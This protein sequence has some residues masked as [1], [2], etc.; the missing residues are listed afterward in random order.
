MT[1]IRRDPIRRTMTAPQTSHGHPRPSPK[2]ARRPLHHPL[3]QL[4]TRP[5]PRH[6]IAD[7]VAPVWGATTPTPES[8]YPDP[9][10]AEAD[11]VPDAAPATPSYGSTPDIDIPAY[12]PP[13]LEPAGTPEATLEP[14]P[15]PVMSPTGH[16]SYGSVQSTGIG[17]NPFPPTRRRRSHRLRRL[18]A[19]SQARRVVAR[20][21]P[22]I[23]AHP[24]PRSR[25]RA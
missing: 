13:P 17:S 3:L 22:P 6:P 20:R 21:T 24:H 14:P 16:G 5:R 2:A 25:R 15:A 8:A 1:R 11:T 12:T 4:T 9:A 23:S 19:V 10:E 18:V 7:A